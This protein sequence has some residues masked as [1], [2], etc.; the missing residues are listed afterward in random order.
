M[1]D[2]VIAMG[3]GAGIDFD[4]EKARA[5]NTFDAHRMLQLA[6]REGADE[7][8]L[9]DRLF[10]AYF[11]GSSDLSEASD[12]ARLT[13]GSGVDREQSEAVAAGDEF[14][15]EVKADQE[16]AAALG[17]TGVPAFVFDRRSGLSGAQPVD[18]M[19]EAIDRA[20]DPLT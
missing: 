8:A 10:E 15:P 4:F 1:N 14:G 2:R 7:A 13:S 5:V 17:I 3:H 11:T 6:T 18:V 19:R 9:A 20:L 12:L 16:L